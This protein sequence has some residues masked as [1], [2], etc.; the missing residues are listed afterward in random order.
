VLLGASVLAH[1]DDPHGVRATL[2]A[3]RGADGLRWA[4]IHLLEPAGWALPGLTLLLALPR[5]AGVA[6]RGRALLTAAAVACVTGFPAVSLI[7]YGHGRRNCPLMGA[8]RK[9][10]GQPPTPAEPRG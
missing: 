5:M 6:G 9:C 2:A 7:V 1:P 3:I 10:V 8:V 4:L